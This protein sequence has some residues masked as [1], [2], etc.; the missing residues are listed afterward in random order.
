MNKQR[1]YTKSCSSSY[2]WN[3]RVSKYLFLWENTDSLGH[4]QSLLLLTLW[5][6]GWT[7]DGSW[8]RGSPLASSYYRLAPASLKQVYLCNSQELA[9]RSCYPNRSVFVCLLRPCRPTKRFAKYL[10]VLLG[11]SSYSDKK[12]KFHK[13][14]LFEFTITYGS[15]NIIKTTFGIMKRSMNQ[16]GGR[17][18]YLV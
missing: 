7:I 10:P 8:K 18:A 13:G 12:G 11:R 1:G 5:V 2:K 15:T 16:G 9:T 4:L 17:F 3:S 14:K 6:L